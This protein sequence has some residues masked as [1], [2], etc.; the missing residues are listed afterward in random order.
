MTTLR[1][2]FPLALLAALLMVSMGYA[3]SCCG[4]GNSGALGTITSFFGGAVNSLKAPATQVGT[5]AYQPIPRQIAAAQPQRGPAPARLQSYSNPSRVRRTAAA[6]LSSCCS[7]GGTGYQ[8]RTQYS[9]NYRQVR[10]QAALGAVSGSCCGGGGYTGRPTASSV[11]SC[12]SSGT[13]SYTGYRG[14]PAPSA[15]VPSCCS[16]QSG[17]TAGYKAAPSRPVRVVQA[18]GTRSKRS[19]SSWGRAAGSGPYGNTGYFSKAQRLW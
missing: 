10:P 17:T 1:I 15:G 2:A 16:V 7:S 8:A 19:S 6:S 9:P 11:P 4:S 13:G 14:A 5:R 12:C 3:Q 18:S